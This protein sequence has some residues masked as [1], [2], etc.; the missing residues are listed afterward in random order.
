MMNDQS[1]DYSEKAMSDE[2]RL[3]YLAEMQ[4]TQWNLRHPFK[5]SEIVYDINDVSEYSNEINHPSETILKAIDTAKNSFSDEKPNNFKNIVDSSKDETNIARNNQALS[6]SEQSTPAQST[7]DQSN[8]NTHEFDANQFLKL[9][10][11]SSDIY[12]QSSVELT[13]TASSGEMIDKNVL[14]VCRHKV[15]Q[16]AN[17]FAN[18][19]APSRFMQDY[20]K[21]L[22]E[23]GLQNNLRLNI[24]LAHLSEAGLGKNSIRIET[25][26]DKNRPHKTLVLGDETVVNLI[27]KMG[28]VK[29]SRCR[30][31]KLFLNVNAIVSYHPFDLISN[32]RLKSLAYEDLHFL[33]NDLCQNSD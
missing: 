8:S 15:D 23:I 13:N 9:V 29:S 1:S 10:D 22:V 4:I 21:T 2:S 31:N 6:N 18:K 5:P 28:D 30:L 3:K 14:L 26:Y 24:Q 12:T 27:D 33:I 25:Y 7:L 11:W 20:L 17:S 19:Q 16:P 32:P